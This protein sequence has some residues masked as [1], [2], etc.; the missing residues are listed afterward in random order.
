[1]GV[2]AAT[3]IYAFIGRIIARAMGEVE[4]KQALIAGIA[5]PAILTNVFNGASEG[6]K[7]TDLFF[8]SQAIAQSEAPSTALQNW[9]ANSKAG[10]AFRV[11]TLAPDPNV[12]GASGAM[13]GHMKKPINVKILTADKDGKLHDW[14]S[15]QLGNSTAN[16]T[17]AIPES[18]AKIVFG[19]R[20]NLIVPASPD[21]VK[22]D[23]N[24][25]PKNTF[26]DGFWWALGGQADHNVNVK[27]YIADTQK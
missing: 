15:G 26:S 20:V 11:I 9:K 4:M 23:W 8:M 19:D 2:A 1:L 16:T 18:Q 21:D 10:E 12:A 14:Y 17:I 27:A 6:K 24:V 13:L 7:L 25:T 3:A 5:A 22:A